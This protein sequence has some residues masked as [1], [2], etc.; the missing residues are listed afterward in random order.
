MERDLTSEL[1]EAL[2]GAG[3][4]DAADLGKPRFDLPAGVLEASVGDVP[5]AGP[6]AQGLPAALWPLH[7]R[8]V[9][10]QPDGRARDVPVRIAEFVTQVLHIAIW[11]Q[12]GYTMVWSM[13]IHID[14]PVSAWDDASITEE[15][16]GPANMDSGSKRPREVA[17]C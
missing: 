15:G 4:T 1:F 14:I 5:G 2:E 7:D 13:G 10:F 16:G 6:A 9:P 8:P 17:D 12:L 3:F 11:S